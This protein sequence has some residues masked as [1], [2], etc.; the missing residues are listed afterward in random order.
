MFF[1]DEVLNEAPSY[2]KDE[3]I[4]QKQAEKQ[5][6]YNMMQQMSE[7]VGMDGQRLRDYLDVQ[8]K[9]GLYSVG[10]VLLIT[11]QNPDATLLEDYKTWK[12]RGASILR[13]EKGI[14]ILEPSGSYTRADGQTVAGFNT[15]KVFDISQTT[16]AENAKPRVKR[17]GKLLL[18]ALVKF[19]PCE[20]EKDDQWSKVPEGMIAFY[21]PS[22][23]AIFVESGH[24]E[25]ELFRAIS[26]ELAFAYL[27]PGSQNR[28]ENQFRAECVSY[29]ICRRN[30]VDVSGIPFEQL[31]ESFS[32]KSP[33]AIRTELSE[34]RNTA[35]QIT[36]DMNRLFEKQKNENKRDEAR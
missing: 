26:R 27:A 20:V 14:L 24:T 19:A 8:A 18:K 5:S 23:R 13:G 11:A 10:N 35:M 3:W 28:E 12:E 9:F 32:Q 22:C 7:M 29:I 15:K 31:S 34:I 2:D 21:D 33:K 17:D 16:L 1:M 6:A 30:Q 36:L 25:D 4:H